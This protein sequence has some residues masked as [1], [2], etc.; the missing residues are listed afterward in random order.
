MSPD[1]NDSGGSIPTGPVP[2]PPPAPPI[3]GVQPDQLKTIVT[4]WR[5]EATDIAKLPWATLSEA[6]GEGSEV[7]A[8]VRG[9]ADP[10]KQAMTS[11]ETRYATLADLVDRFSADVGALDEEIGFEI[12]RLRPR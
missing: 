5:R 7:L 11:I 2:Q 10:A 8:A 6:V 4:T 1:P 9:T 3:L 12:G